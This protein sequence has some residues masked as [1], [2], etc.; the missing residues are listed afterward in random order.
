LLPYVEQRSLYERFDL[1][2]HV[3]A[4]PSG[5][6]AEQPAL[7]LCPSG[8]ARGRM[9]EFRGPNGATIR[10]GKANYAAY[11]SPYHTDDFDHQGAFWAY[12]IELRQVEDGLSRT[13]ALSEIRTRDQPRDQ[14]GAW[15]LPWNGASLLAFDMHPAEFPD[16][17]DDARY[18][19]VY[20]P[21][22]LGFTQV[23]NSAQPDVLYEC[24]D[25]IGEQLDRMPCTDVHYGYIS[26]APRSNHP[27][28]V[29]LS[30]LDGSSKFV[31]D[32]VD[33][34]AM[35]YAVA[36]DDGQALDAGFP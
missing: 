13:V 30:M 9:F 14:R 35:A 6:Q 34:I 10:F 25:L 12:G 23:P 20:N 17:L 2:A 31:S 3:S 24:P 36:I 21:R 28:G 33:E 11:A 8:E 19:F 18:D 4:N 26:A 5:P 29:H 32:Q 15:A 22:S 16:K 7:L 27:G 1:T